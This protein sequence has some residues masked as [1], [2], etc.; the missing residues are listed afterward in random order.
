MENKNLKYYKLVLFSLVLII[1]SIYVFNRAHYYESIASRRIVSTEKRLKILHELYNIIINLA[2]ENNIK[3]FIIYGTLLGK[4]RN[5]DIICYD[6]D[7]DFGISSNDYEL[8]RQSILKYANNNKQYIVEDKKLLWWKAI[9]L[10]DKETGLNADIMVYYNNKTHVWRSISDLYAKY[11][12]NECN[13]NLPIDWI[14]PLQKSTFLGRTIYLPNKP[15]NILECHYGSD[16]M[17]P[18]H[19]CNIDCSICISK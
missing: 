14:Y 17:I 10:V 5:N 8:M 15:N 6:F 12:L 3:V 11:I 16:F 13:N 2:E 19:T 7:L 1:I 4:I 9:A 18:N